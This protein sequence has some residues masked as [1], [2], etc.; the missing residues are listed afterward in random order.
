MAGRGQGR[1]VDGGVQLGRDAVDMRG[2]QDWSAVSAE[3][4]L[5]GDTRDRVWRAGAVKRQLE[6]TTD[7]EQDEGMKAFKEKQHTTDGVYFERTIQPINRERPGQ[8]PGELG[9]G[10]RGEA[11]RCP[12]HTVGEEARPEP[13]L[14]PRQLLASLDPRVTVYRKPDSRRRHPAPVRHHRVNSNTKVPGTWD[15]RA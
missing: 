14:D 2:G 5:H 4:K 12:D 15:A 3:K 13:C 10:E 8:Q 1:A 11:P 7:A 9:A 6:Q